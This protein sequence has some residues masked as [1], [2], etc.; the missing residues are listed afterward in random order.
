MSRPALRLSVY[1][2]ELDRMDGGLLSDALLDLFARHEVDVA[3]LLRAVEGFGI[4][5]RLRTQRLLTLSEDL[6][7][8]ALALGEADRVEGLLPELDTML[9]EGLVTIERARLVEPGTVPEA[10]LEGLGPQ[11][12]LSAF[13]A[14]ARRVGGEPAAIAHLRHLGAG[15]VA[16]GVALLGVDGVV[17]GERRRARFL[18]GNADVPAMV[19]AVADRES[20]ARALAGLPPALAVTLERVRVDKVA[21]RA[22]GDPAESPEAD[23]GGLGVWHRRVVHTEDGARAGGR[24]L[25]LELV[26]QLRLAG[27]AGATVLRGVAGVSGDGPVRTERA[28]ALRRH[29]PLVVTVVDRPARM[30][31]LW[32]IVDALTAE[33]GLVT[34]EAVPAVRATGPGIRMGGL[35]LAEPGGG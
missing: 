20:A 7:L 2:G 12:K 3:V 21:G 30:R 15:G 11:V 19:L 32:P 34:S 4:K 1:F 31:R 16:G 6:P 17:A 8:L 9:P 26:R 27:A 33:T 25:A 22:L 5:H 24:P 35:R 14:R 29:A 23:A 13:V 10:A 28:L 18:S